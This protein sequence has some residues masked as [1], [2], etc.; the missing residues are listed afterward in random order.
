MLVQ[1]IEPALMLYSQ[2]N[3]VL[4]LLRREMA[5]STALCMRKKPMRTPPQRKVT[6]ITV[7]SI[8]I[9]ILVSL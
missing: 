3:T 5:T 2:V 4:A 9:I 8:I 7:V 6:V 1:A